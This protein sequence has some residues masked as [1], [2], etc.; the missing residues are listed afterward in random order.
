MFYLVDI[1]ASIPG[2]LE[3]SDRLQAAKIL[4]EAHFLHEFMSF[5]TQIVDVLSNLFSWRWGWEKS[6][7]A[8]AFEI[9]CHE[10]GPDAQSN[11]LYDTF[12]YYQ[13]FHKG[14][15]PMLYNT[16]LLLV[17]GLARLWDLKDAPASAISKLPEQHRPLQSNPLA[18]PHKNLSL[19]EISAEICK[20]FECMYFRNHGASASAL[21]GSIRH[22]CAPKPALL[23]SDLT[24]RDG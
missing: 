16:A 20:S 22:R 6:H 1:L 19:N 24:T 13:N 8:V 12:L 5:H 11:G 23:I 4:S 17:F 18:L 7:P 21:L 10:A 2:L 3:L 9:P 14:R 15:E